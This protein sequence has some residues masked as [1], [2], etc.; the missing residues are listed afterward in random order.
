ML[1]FA[2]QASRIN[3]FLKRAHI[4]WSFC[5]DIATLNELLIKSNSSLFQ[6]M[7]SSV[8]CL[9]SLLP[10]K[11]TVDYQLRNRHCQYVLPQCNFNLLKHSFV[12]WCLF[13]LQCCNVELLCVTV[14]VGYCHIYARLLRKF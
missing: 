9:N 5:K 3:A 12:N 4:K 11:K 2:G 7:Q 13:T 6:K 8:H 1:V 10:P 14:I